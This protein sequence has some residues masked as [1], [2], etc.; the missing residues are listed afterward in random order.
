MSE[1]Q[2]RVLE[3]W[4]NVF[5]TKDIKTTDNFFEIGGDSLKGMQIFMDLSGQLKSF[6]VSDFFEYQTVEDI[7][8]KI[9]SEDLW[10]ERQ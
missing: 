7:S 8:K 1:T 9:D 2:R 6:E 4:C 3:I 5:Q 10:M